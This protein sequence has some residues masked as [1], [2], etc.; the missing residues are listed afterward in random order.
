M[1]ETQ[2]VEPVKYSTARGLIKGAAQA[3]YTLW[4]FAGLGIVDVLAQV[5]MNEA[6]TGVVLGGFTKDHP[7]LLVLVPLISGAARTYW[8]K[9]QVKK[10]EK[11]AA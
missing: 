11:A 8:N 7:S 1:P 2:T 4:G 3:V 9:R 6:A 10:E 5:L